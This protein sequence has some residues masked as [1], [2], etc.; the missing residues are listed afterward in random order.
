MTNIDTHTDRQIDRLI[1]WRDRLERGRGGGGGRKGGTD[2]RGRAWLRMAGRMGGQADG[3]TGR[4]T[5]RE[6]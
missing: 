3:R 2:G 1:D 4:H 5:H 6:R